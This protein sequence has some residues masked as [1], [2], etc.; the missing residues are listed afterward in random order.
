MKTIQCANPPHHRNSFVATC[1]L[2][3]V[4]GGVHA[5]LVLQ[6]AECSTSTRL[7]Y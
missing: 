7:M 6:P 5:F 3:T 2:C 1:R 4:S